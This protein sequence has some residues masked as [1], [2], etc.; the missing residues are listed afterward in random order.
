MNNDG[1]PPA[2]STVPP[3]ARPRK[4]RCR[5]VPASH[6]C[7]CGITA[8][9]I[10][11]NT[12]VLASRKRDACCGSGRRWL[13][14]LGD[15]YQGGAAPRE[16]HRFRRRRRRAIK[17]GLRRAAR[18]ARRRGCTGGTGRCV[19]CLLDWLLP[20]RSR[21]PSTGHVFRR[22]GHP[23]RI[24]DCS[25]DSTHGVVTD[26][27]AAAVIARYRERIPELMAEQGVPGL[28][29][30]LVDGDRVV[31]VEGFGPADDEAAPR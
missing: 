26:N 31:W 22:N 15:A 8:A 7:S 14:V 19:G 2:G 13:L 30:A 9:A 29:V 27:A 10:S 28:A 1:W 3:V 16:N 17:S 21:S 11:A 4:A 5:A 24:L 25:V 12:D 18:P 23:N 6:A 20:P